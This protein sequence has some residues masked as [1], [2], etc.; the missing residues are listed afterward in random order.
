M[1]KKTQQDYIAEAQELFN[2]GFT[3]KAKKKDA[4]DKLARAYSEARYARDTELR[5]EREYYVNGV[6]D[7][8]KYASFCKAT[9]MYPMDLHNIRERHL[10]EEIFGSHVAIVTELF[11]LRAAIKDADLVPATV[12]EA[13]LIIEEERACAKAVKDD[14]FRLDQWLTTQWFDCVSHLG[15]AYIRVNW[16]KQGEGLVSFARI[17][18]FVGPRRQFWESKGKPN[19]SKWSYDEIENFYSELAA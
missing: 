17:C 1:I 13:K 14:G 16:Y 5:L 7:E 3:S 4:T 6:V 19:M 15:N 8:V 11:E 12:S 10:N 2:L 18:K 9:D